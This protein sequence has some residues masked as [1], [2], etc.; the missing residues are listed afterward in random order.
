MCNR[1]SNNGIHFSTLLNVLWWKTYCHGSH[2][3]TWTQSFV[4]TVQR[5]TI[6]NERYITSLAV[7]IKEVFQHSNWAWT[8]L[9]L[10]NI[11]VSQHQE[12]SDRYWCVVY[13]FYWKTNAELP[14]ATISK[15]SSAS[16]NLAEKSEKTSH[17]LTI[18]KNTVPKHIHTNSLKENPWQANSH[19]PS[20][21]TPCIF[22]NSK[23]KLPCP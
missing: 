5:Y 19:S 9:W 16:N 11:H 10:S 22:W 15:Q 7:F 20:Q 8:W 14:S 1:Y 2:V 6:P 17:V 21:Y 13:V 12:F 3:L 4:V 23:V 18:Q